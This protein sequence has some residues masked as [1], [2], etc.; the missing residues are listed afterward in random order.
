[1]AVVG[2]QVRRV[3]DVDQVDVRVGEQVVEAL[4]LLDGR[5]VHHARRAGR[6][7]RGCRASR[8]PASSGRGCRR[9]RAS[10]PCRCL[11]GEVV[12]HA[13]EAD[14]DD[15]DA[16]H[17]EP[18]GIS[19]GVLV[20]RP[21]T[22]QQGNGTAGTTGT[23]GSV[24]EVPAVPEEWERRPDPARYDRQTTRG[25]RMVADRLAR[26]VT[27]LAASES[28]DADLLRRFVATR[29]EARRSHYRPPAWAD[30]V[31]RLS[32]N[33]AAPARRGGCISSRLSGSRPKGGNCASEW[34]ESLALRRRRAGGAQG[35]VPGGRDVPPPNCRRSRPRWPR[36]RPTGCRSWTR[37]W[38][39]FPDRDRGP[40]LLCDLLGRTR[41]EAAAELGIAEGTL[42]ESAGAG[43]QQAS[44]PAR[45]SRGRP[46]ANDPRR[47]PV[48]PG[49][50]DGPDF[51][52]RIRRR[53]RL[54]GRRRPRTGRRSAANHV[55]RENAQGDGDS[56]RRMRG[57]CGRGDLAADGRA[58]AAP[59][60]GHPGAGR[61]TGETG[62]EG[63]A[64]G[65]DETAPKAAGRTG[66]GARG[67]SSTG[68]S[69][70]S[71]SARTR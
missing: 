10:R 51:P 61:R 45:P 48:R 31:R 19:G 70:G 57:R 64:G 3:A 52:D 28:A 41:A 66:R 27:R 54:L 15:A 33:V 42:S 30:G 35:P 56:G 2:V 11:G 38:H 39:A 46:V 24:P 49:G 21:G 47:R 69:N 8:R 12:N 7:C 43:P 44:G 32:T 36:C 58:G 16:N 68:S 22:G 67:R 63:P 29:D 18:R 4:V 23:D 5:Q 25:P 20:M 14:A 9:P 13:H 40:I 17:R 1:M 71:R 6:S 55:P 60:R 34:A 50:R 26:T 65:P 37:P 62:R 53:G 59:T